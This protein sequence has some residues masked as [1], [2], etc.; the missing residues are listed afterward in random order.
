V[1]ACNQPAYNPNDR[2][3]IIAANLSKPRRDRHLRAGL[4]HKPFFVAAGIASG[5]Y[6]DRS[7]ID[8]SPG[9]YKVGAK[10][11]EDEHN[12]GAVK[13]ATVLRRARTWAWRESR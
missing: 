2:E 13:N 8:T 7:I 9:F 11:F 3:Q 10:I 6:D 1:L 12:L 4:V 5:K